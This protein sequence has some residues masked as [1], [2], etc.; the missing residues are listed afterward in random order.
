[1]KRHRS[2][3]NTKTGNAAQSCVV[4]RGFSVDVLQAVAQAS[5][6]TLDEAIEQAIRLYLRDRELRPPGWEH[7]LL[8]AQADGGDARSEVE[9]PVAGDTLR[10]FSSLAGDES[11]SVDELA[12]Q[13]VMYLW[14][15]KRPPIRSR[16]E[17]RQDTPDVPPSGRPPR[18]GSRRVS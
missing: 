4:L 7:L 3:A 18:L 17:N 16:Q 11:V 6:W 12:S 5:D 9:I 15:Q 13:A 1:M 2:A 8:P 10:S 14:A